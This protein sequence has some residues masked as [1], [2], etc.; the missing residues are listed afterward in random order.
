MKTWRDVVLIN[1]GLWIPPLLWATSLQL[2]QILPYVDC[3][4]PSRSSAATAFSAMAITIVAGAM[5]WRS[6]ARLREGG[7]VLR[8]VAVIATMSAAVFAYAIALQAGATLVL[9]GCER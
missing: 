7:Y 8:S 4:A 5:S 9:S 6:A 1:I 2:G 3:T